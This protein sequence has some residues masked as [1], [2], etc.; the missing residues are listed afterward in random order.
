LNLLFFGGIGI[1]SNIDFSKFFAGIKIVLI[2]ELKIREYSLLRDIVK[3]NQAL[4][5]I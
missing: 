5:K 3:N 2:I 1:T 4:L